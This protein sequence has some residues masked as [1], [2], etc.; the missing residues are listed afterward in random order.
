MEKPKVKII[1]AGPAGFF[2]AHT[3]ADYA[4]ITILDKGRE[5]NKRKCPIK[6]GQVNSCIN[7]NPCNV[8]CG[9]GGAG[10][11]SDGKLL[12]S[13]KIGNNLSISNTI[14][15]KENQELVDSVESIF[16]EYG[17]EAVQKNEKKLSEIET[18]ALRNDIEFVYSKQGH[19][20]SENLPDLMEKMKTDLESRG[21][22]FKSREKVTNL[23]DLEYDYVLLAPGRSGSSWLE[24]VMKEKQ[25]EYNYKAADIGIRIEVPKEITNHI[26]DVVRDMKFY[27]RSKSYNDLVRTF[28]TCPGGHVSQ[29][30][31]EGFTLVNGHAES[32]SNSPN[33]NFALLTTIPLKTSNSNEYAKKIAQMGYILRKKSKIT[34]QRLGDLHRGRKS[35]AEDNG[36]HHLIPTLKEAEWGDISLILPARHFTN[37]MEGMVELEK[38]MPGLLNGSTLLYA[39]EIKFHGLDI[40]TN[41][42]LKAGDGIYV[43]GDGAGMSR[44]IVGAAAS[45][46]LAAKGI[47]KEIRK[48]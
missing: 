48:T 11:M 45:G 38:I 17:I 31:H 37:I 32:N 9:V 29:E 33:T 46:L 4:D 34:V 6:E 30:T 25:I 19:I 3:L 24:K 8:H 10:L 16:K 23:N 21:V 40:K 5:I 13:T 1:G 2:A 27:V 20:G 18:L 22:Q 36:K 47:L 15:E 35:K 14:T 28:C 7:C 26:T 39:P 42:Y 41:K 44:G 43:A 12:F